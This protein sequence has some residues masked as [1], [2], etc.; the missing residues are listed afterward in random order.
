[1]NGDRDDGCRWANKKRD[2]LV[3]DLQQRIREYEAATG[4]M[5]KDVQLHHAFRIGMGFC[6]AKVE[7]VVVLP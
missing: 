2:G 4:M 7:V 1:M 6:T 3:A 5:V